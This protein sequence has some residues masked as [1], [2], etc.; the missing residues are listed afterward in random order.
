MQPVATEGPVFP[1]GVL[2][3][4]LYRIRIL[5]GPDTQKCLG[6]IMEPGSVE[7]LLQLLHA[8][9]NEPVSAVGRVFGGNRDFFPQLH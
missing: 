9:E 5:S 8:Q 2:P 3:K 6:H 4:R 7:Q 1:S